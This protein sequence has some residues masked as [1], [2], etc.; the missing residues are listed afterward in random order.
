MEGHPVLVSPEGTIRIVALGGAGCIHQ[1]ANHHD[2]VIKAPLKH[3]TQGCN[4]E[5]KESVERREEFSELC[6][7][8]E[9]LI[10]QSL[11]SDTPNIL[12]CFAITDRGI[13]LPY[14]QYGDVRSYLQQHSINDEMRHRW[15]ENAVNA[16]S[17]IHTYGIIHAD[18]SSR[19]FLVANDLSIRL[20]DF[21]GSRI[22]GL[23]SLVE[24]ETR[25]RL[26]SSTSRTITTDIFAL[27]SFI[28]EVSTGLRPFDE[29]DDEDDIE[30]MFA[31]HVFPCLDGLEF[32]QI[33][34][35]CWK[36]QYSSV[37][38]I[39]ADLDSNQATRH[40]ATFSLGLLIPAS[41]I[42]GLGYCY[43]M[44]KVRRRS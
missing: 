19:N 33:I 5:T 4:Q 2:R 3:N 38:S 29:I 18:I 21:A 10:Y 28:Y 39:R 41:L 17:T 35:K 12:N 11:P 42:A 23:D 34:I 30:R 40:T 9:K 16:I 31:E 43:W 8:R 26:P 24:E 15:V 14:L 1:D 27:G 13:Q 44:S 32:R 36:S 6:I 25:Y 20:C 7:S 22:N 37:D